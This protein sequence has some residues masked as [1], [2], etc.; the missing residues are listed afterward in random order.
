MVS[1]MKLELISV[2]KAGKFAG[3]KLEPA[4]RTFLRRWAENCADDSIWEE[5][6]V[7]AR[8]SRLFPEESLR[9]TV[10]DYALHARRLAHSVKYGDDPFFREQQTK[11]VELLSLA[12]KADDLA[13]YFQEAEKYSGVANFFHRFLVLPLTPEQ[14]RV[15]RIEPSVL[16][17]QQLRKIHLQEAHLLRQR[18]GRAPTPTVFISRKKAKR[19]ITAFIHLM[20]N[21]MVQMCGKQQ[22]RA[23]A[24]LASMAFDSSVD[25]EDVRKT[26]APSTKGGR[27]RKNRAFSQEKT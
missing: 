3:E 26:L 21:Y 1:A 15:P 12:Q 18:A 19:V 4:D 13:F 10:I 16:R 17:V 6:M 23:V 22:R 9:A 24:L 25:E 7:G 8:A 2:L 20:T 27:T 11:R 5:I 14:E